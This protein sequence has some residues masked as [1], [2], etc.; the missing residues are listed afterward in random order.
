MPIVDQVSSLYG[1]KAY[2]TVRPFPVV[3]TFDSCDT[4]ITPFKHLYD[5]I[6]SRA[7]KEAKWAFEARLW[8]RQ[9]EGWI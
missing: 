8:I 2:S 7:R 4:T 1:C 3:L 5:F 9:S 6:A